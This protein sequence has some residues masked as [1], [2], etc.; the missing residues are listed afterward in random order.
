LLKR[1]RKWRCAEAGKGQPVAFQR[2]PGMEDVSKHK[3]VD[4]MGEDHE[5]FLKEDSDAEKVEVWIRK[6]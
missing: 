4:D 5:D 6:L 1:P 3:G 2:Q